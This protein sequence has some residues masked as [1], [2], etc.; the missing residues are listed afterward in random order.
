[1]CIRD[2][3]YRT[4]RR[5]GYCGMD[6]QN[7]QKFRAGI[8]TELTEVPGRYKNAIHIPRVLWHGRTDLTEVPGTGVNVVQNSEVLCM[9]M[10]VVQ[11]SH[12]FRVRVIPA[13]KY[14]PSGEEFDLKGRISS[15]L[16]MACSHWANVPEAIRSCVGIT[17]NHHPGDKS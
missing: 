2:R 1:M 3:S 16:H 5:S 15:N 13:G 12:K 9:G 7:L 17:G 10:D 14:T 4:S 6:L 11:N 8:N